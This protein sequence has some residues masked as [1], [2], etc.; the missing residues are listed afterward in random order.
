MTSGQKKV[1]AGL[2][3]LIVLAF[4]LLLLALALEL[5]GISQGDQA[6]ISELM[7]LLWANQP[8]VVLLVSH[9]LAAPL[10]F[11]AGHFFAAPKDEYARLRGEK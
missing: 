10:W 6:T 11:L 4:G 7:R 2:G 9:V 5:F 1:A 8:W 3:C